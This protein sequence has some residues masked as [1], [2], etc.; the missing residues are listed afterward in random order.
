MEFMDDYRRIY[1]S[2]LGK[3]IGVRLGSPIEGWTYEQIRK[4]YAPVHGYTT[5]YGQYAADD[6]LNGPLFFARVMEDHTIEEVTPEDMGNNMLNV[7]APLHGFYWWGGPGIATEHTA[8]AN[9]QKGIKAPLSGSAS[10]NGKTIAEQIGGQIFSDCWGFLSLGSPQEAADMAAKMSSVTHDLDG[11]EGGKFVAVCIALAWHLHDIREIIEESRRYLDP[12]STYTALI[13]EFL[14]FHEAHPDDPQACLDYIHAHHGYDKYTGACHILP[15][16]AI[17]LYGMLYGRNSFNETMRLIAEAGCDTDCNLGNTGAIM[18]MMLGLE[19][20]DEK[21]ILPFNDILLS[22]SSLAARNI[23]TI[24]GTA[25]YFTKLAAKLH[26]LPVPNVSPFSLPYATHGFRAETNADHAV[27]TDARHGELRLIIDRLL[28]KEPFKVYRTT[29]F[30]PEDVYDVRYEP[31]FTG[32]L[33]PG[34]TVE[35]TLCSP[36]N[37]RLSFTPYIKDYEGKIIKGEKAQAGTVRWTVPGGVLPLLETGLIVEGVAYIERTLFTI[38][39][40]RIHKH[41]SATINFTKTTVEDWGTDIGLVPRY[42]LSGLL[43]HEGQAQKAEDGV[44]LDPHS[45]INFSGPDTLYRCAQLKVKASPDADLLF[46][47]T[48][49]GVRRHEG[50]RIHGSQASVYHRYDDAY[51]ETPLGDFTLTD[52]CTVLCFERDKNTLTINDMKF[53]TDEFKEN[54]G[55]LMVRNQS[56]APLCIVQCTYRG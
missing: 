8:Y 24:S 27:H 47:W 52:D 56:D 37:L 18:G 12:E 5:D 42:G 45:A 13:N 19:G 25:L 28:E 14:S 20:I 10:T 50:I 51:T 31:Q 9:L 11:I 38:T 21:W 48:Y 40:F 17:M 1:A 39:D 36:D 35:Y 16:T 54:R 55:A 26:N 2:W 7:V 43:I 4:T 41:P 46:S 53:F 49:Q 29:Y 34:D 32:L 23:D 44:V 30:R 15:N 33:E 3:C 22:S 6:D